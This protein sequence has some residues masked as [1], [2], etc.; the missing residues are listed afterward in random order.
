M[1]AKR[2]RVPPRDGRSAD[3]VLLRR[4]RAG[5]IAHVGSKAERHTNRA[6]PPGSHADTAPGTDGCT[7][8]RRARRHPHRRDGRRCAP[9]PI[10]H[11]SATTRILSGGINPTTDAW[12]D[13]V[14]HGLPRRFGLLA[15]SR[16][17]RQRKQ[18]P[19]FYTLRLLTTTTNIIQILLEPQRCSGQ[20]WL[21]VVAS[22]PARGDSLPG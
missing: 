13:T 21:S 20:L 14:R 18:F 15:P 22:Q 7:G 19:A 2:V 17:A 3:A 8:R 10:A 12:A 16:T 11:S 6:D 1:V 9:T 4:T 5:L